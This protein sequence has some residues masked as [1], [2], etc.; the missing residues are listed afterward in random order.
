MNEKGPEVQHGST[1]EGRRPFWRGHG[2]PRPVFLLLI[3]VL[4]AIAVAGHFNLQFSPEVVGLLPSSIPEAEG[5]Q[6]YQEHF[7]G[8]KEVIL[9]V[10]GE[11]PAQVETAARFLGENLSTEETG[12]NVRRALWQPAWMDSPE[13]L[14]E[15]VG[16]MR[17]NQNPEIFAR[18]A[19]RLDPA[20][21]D[22]T[23]DAAVTRLTAS[24]SPA[25]MALGGMDPY[26]LADFMGPGNGSAADSQAAGDALMSMAD[27]DA[28]FVGRTGKLRIVYVTLEEPFGSYRAAGEW[29]DALRAQIKEWKGSGALPESVK[30]GYTGEPV[31]VAEVS[32]QMESS[33]TWSVALTTLI[34]AALFYLFYRQVLPL[35]ALLLMLGCIIGLTVGIGGLIIHEL[36]MI[37]VGFAAII[38]GLT[39][40]YGVILFQAVRQEPTIT[41]RE[42]RARLGLSIFWAALTTA[43]VFGSAILS[44]FPAVSQLGAL[45]AIGTIAGSFLAVF[46]FAPLWTRLARLGV[47]RTSGR[48]RPMPHLARH[49]PVS[50]VIALTVAIPLITVLVFATQGLPGIDGSRDAL[51]P[52]QSQAYDTMDQIESAVGSGNNSIGARGMALMIDGETIAETTENLH[53]VNRRLA[54]MQQEGKIRSY[55]LPMPF[56]PDVE[57]LRRNLPV[58]RELARDVPVLREKALEAGFTEEALAL[59]DGMARFWQEFEL[60]PQDDKVWPA[61][62]GSEWIISQFISTGEDAKNGG[63]AILGL[64]FPAEGYE[65]LDLRNDLIGEGY[66]PLNWELVSLAILRVVYEDLARMAGPIVVILLA[67]LFLVFRRWQEVVL[68]LAV[69][70]FACLGLLAGMKLLG[71]QWNFLNLM[72]APL[73]VGAG[74]DY[75]IHVLLA[76]RR[77]TSRREVDGIRRA[78]LL[79]GASTAA[80][81]GSLG[82]SASAGLASLGQ[83]CSVGILLTTVTAVYLL[84]VWWR[85]V[86][87][88]TP[89]WEEDAPSRQAIAEEEVAALAD[90]EE[91]TATSRQPTS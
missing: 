37:N 48:S 29:Y 75:G 12:L 77:H 41:T 8:V 84:P 30:L 83:L 24:F 5:L 3:P 28:A 1:T 21:A 74:L 44:K 57:N 91:Q 89:P 9:T 49:L 43:C 27:G 14:A 90:H 31:F 80:G 25:D 40:D 4:L 78:L 56:W 63:Y 10:Q 70:S 6:I 50:A 81:F 72:A 15:L 67:V 66:R 33:M 42:L 79:C 82:F 85:W 73:L 62:D 71:W 59:L 26:G 86:V 39:V 64:A 19:E 34:V 18:F 76:L 45:V 2:L 58:A 51:R 32:R 16:W 69:L 20:R 11:D 7:S 22:E 36:N 65:A 46:F 55:Q 68:C 54:D 47:D 38:I 52:R 53:E 61:S 23:L 60:N 13:A 87:R 88:E 35:L 17:L